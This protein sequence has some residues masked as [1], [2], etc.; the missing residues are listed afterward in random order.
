MEPYSACVLMVLLLLLLLPPQQRVQM[1][2]AAQRQ[3]HLVLGPLPHA[4][5]RL[6]RVAPPA[7][8]LVPVATQ[9][10]ATASN[11][12]LGSGQPT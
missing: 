6:L 9:A 8:P 2:Q 12:P 7:M 4:L 5:E 10:M 1:S 11:A 3:S